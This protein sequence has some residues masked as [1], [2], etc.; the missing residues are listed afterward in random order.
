MK[1]LNLLSLRKQKVSKKKTQSIK[2]GENA[3]ACICNAAG[4]DPNRGYLA[5]KASMGC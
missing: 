4:S 3:C 1:K 2:G 5:F